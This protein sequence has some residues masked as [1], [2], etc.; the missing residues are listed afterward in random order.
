MSHLH[1]PD[2]L[3]PVWLWVLGLAVAIAGV[4]FSLY[5]SRGVGLKKKVP[6]LGMMS[7][8]M[9][10]GMNL[11]IVPI[12]YHVNLS[13]ITGIILGPWLAV[14][15]AFIVNIILALV[16]HGGI[17]VVGL[18]TIVV[19]YEGIMGY[20]LF[21]LFKRFMKPGPASAVSTVITLFTST[22]LM[23]LIVLA[24]NVD[25]SAA[26]LSEL[27][28]VMEKP[29]TEALARLFNISGRFDFRLFAYAALGLGTIG[30]TIEAV[31]TAAAVK[32]ISKVKPDM[33]SRT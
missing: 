16:G 12:A 28:D 4:L 6:L 18:N 3:L 5:M 9:L 15:A 33:L 1:I 22:C 13:V 32:F 8:M 20:L 17:T 14:V 21:S 10:V 26:S 24:A 23:L 2:G 29:T 27:R 30:W 7:A 31:V 19:G 11:E 25:F